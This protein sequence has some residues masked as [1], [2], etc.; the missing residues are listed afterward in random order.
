[1]GLLWENISFRFPSI[2]MIFQ[3][4]KAH[5]IGMNPSDAHPVFLT[6]C[7]VYALAI[8]III[9]CAR[10]HTNETHRTSSSIYYFPCIFRYTINKQNR[11]QRTNRLHK[12]YMSTN[13]FLA[14]YMRTAC[15]CTMIIVAGHT[16]CMIMMCMGRNNGILVIWIKHSPT[17]WILDFCIGLLA[18]GIES[19]R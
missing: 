17:Q 13:L 6:P 9:C 19:R 2:H 16:Q 1:M 12:Y 4:E 11:G 15:M 7:K 5:L 3:T 10:T 14:H 18:S 8:Y